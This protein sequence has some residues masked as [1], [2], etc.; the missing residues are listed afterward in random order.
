METITLYGS[1]GTCKTYADL[2]YRE[3]FKASDGRHGKG[4]YLWQVASNEEHSWASINELVE[5]YLK[6]T[7]K[8]RRDVADPTISIL[9]CSMVVSHDN[10]YD[11]ESWEHAQLLASFRRRFEECFSN[12]KKE[13]EDNDFFN[14]YGIN[15]KDDKD[16]RNQ[17]LK[18]IATIVFNSFF[19]TL[20]KFLGKTLDIYVYFIKVQRPKS[21]KR[22]TSIMS[23]YT[24]G[25]YVVRKPSIIEII[26]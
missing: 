18:V 16:Y 20:E 7:E 6:D 12:D 26:A 3:G 13:L 25:C 19:A 17:E 4:V 10:F 14:K 2:I 24:E 22:I 11:C 1:H 23:G 9:R 21:Y 5:C 15:K 8:H